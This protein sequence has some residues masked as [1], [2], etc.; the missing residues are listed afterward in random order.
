[1]EIIINTILFHSSENI[2]SFQIKVNQSN[3]LLV[4][5]KLESQRSKIIEY[6]KDLK[7]EDKIKVLFRKAA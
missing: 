4:I 2:E 3:H 7:Q 6:L 5:K 1:M